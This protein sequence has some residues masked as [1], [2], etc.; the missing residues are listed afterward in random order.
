MSSESSSYLGAVFFFFLFFFFTFVCIHGMKKF[1]GKGSKPL[2]WQQWILNSL[3]HK[4]TPRVVFLSWIKKRERGVP[5]VAQWVKTLTAAA[6]VNAEA[7][8]WSLA[9]CSGLKDLALLQLQ[10]RYDHMHRYDSCAALLNSV[11]LLWSQWKKIY[12]WEWKKKEF[13]C[14]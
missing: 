1:L 12:A 10:H 4:G 14:R 9:Q 7:Q 6:W 11:V 13:N 2:Q 5:S 8:V 3:C